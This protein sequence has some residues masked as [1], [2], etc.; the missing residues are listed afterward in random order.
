MKNIKFYELG[1]LKS[2]WILILPFV[3]I[4]TGY[5]LVSNISPFLVSIGFLTIAIY[6]IRPFIDRNYIAWNKVAMQFKINS[7][8]F[9]I[10]KFKNIKA[11]DLEGQKLTIIFKNSNKSYDISSIQLRDIK[12]LMQIIKSNSN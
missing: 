6:F 12:R 11:L 7:F 3:L 2:D 1:T 10:V 5:I 8:K 9:D 4:P